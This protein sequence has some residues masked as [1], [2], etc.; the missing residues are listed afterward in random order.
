VERLSEWL[1]GLMHVPAHRPVEAAPRSYVDVA[2]GGATAF[3]EARHCVT[4]ALWVLATVLDKKRASI[5]TMLFDHSKMPRTSVPF[6]R[7][8]AFRTKVIYQLSEG[9]MGFDERKE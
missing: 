6:F 9:R 5:E 4:G 2:H 7:S 1:A 3:E 8:S